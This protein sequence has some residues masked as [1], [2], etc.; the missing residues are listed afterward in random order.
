MNIGKFIR[1]I[2]E[3]QQISQKS[4]RDSAEDYCRTDDEKYKMLYY[5]NTARAG[6]FAD[7]LTAISSGKFRD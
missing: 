1:H 3:Q 6:A 5:T 2:E 7:V 4:M